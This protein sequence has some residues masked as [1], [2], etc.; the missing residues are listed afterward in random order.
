MSL[1]VD[2]PIINS[3]FEEPSRWWDYSEGQPVLRD[4]RRPAGYYLRPRT[5]ATAVF[6]NVQSVDRII[7]AIFNRFNEDWQNHTL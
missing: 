4:G 2:N 7:Y 6:T 3:P 1:A 5:R